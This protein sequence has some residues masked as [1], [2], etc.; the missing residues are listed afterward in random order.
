MTAPD[1]PF[2]VELAVSLL[3]LAGGAFALVG[4]IGLVRLRD[5]Y[6]RLHAPTKASTLG[7]GGALLASML[8]FGWTGQRVVVHELL[9]TLFVFMTAPISAHLLVKSALGHE[10]L[11]R[12]PQPEDDGPGGGAATGDAATGDGAG[13]GDALSAPPPGPAAPD[14]PR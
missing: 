4:A 11:R 10:P 7:V 13:P 9:I 14:A 2:A 5:L 8:Y 1:L 6:M 12:P 3:M